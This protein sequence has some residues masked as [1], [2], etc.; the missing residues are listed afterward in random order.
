MTIADEATIRL[1]AFLGVL[2]AMALWE[3]LAPRRPRELSRWVR[4]SNNLGILALDTVLV[5]LAVPLLAVGA[6]LLAA[7]RGWGVLNVLAPPPWLA[8]ALAL[9]LLDFAIYLQHRLFH[10]VAALWRVHRMHHADL[11]LDVTTGLR[12]HPLE[13]VLS[14]LIK[15]AVVLALGA[16]ALAVLAFEVLLNATSIFSHANARL[17]PRLD[18]VLR[19]LPATSA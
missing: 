5:R 15:L 19:R 1:G 11:E 7:E 6:A 12:F 8:F 2:A 10:A 17:P 9:V 14:T 4:W 13:I 3:A 16:P 18:R